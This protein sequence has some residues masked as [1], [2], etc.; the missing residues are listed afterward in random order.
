MALGSDAVAASGILRIELQ[1]ALD[2]LPQLRDFYSH[3]LELRVDE[4]PDGLTIRAGGTTLHFEGVASGRPQYHFAFNIPEN[5]LAAAKRWLAPRC[6]LVRT[7]GDR[8][9]FDF[10]SWNAHAVYFHDP[11]GNIVEWIAR[12]NLANAREGPFCAGDILYASEI[13][14]VVDDVAQIAALARRELGLPVFGGS[15]SAEFAALGDDHRLLIVS[16]RGREWTAGRGLKADVW[17][18]RATI[19]GDRAGRLAS[20]EHR[21]CV[22][23]TPGPM[24]R[25]ASR[26]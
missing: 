17:P 8:D 12:H 21:F 1:C 24:N 25:E 9:E 22:E 18:V 6:E 10:P 4:A 16:R 19:A 26:Q 13:A 20:N 5:K 3:V 7:P 2:L 23:M 14:V 15:I 11:A